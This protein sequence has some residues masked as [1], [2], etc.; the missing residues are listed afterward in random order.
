[1][2]T[3]TFAGVGSAF[4]THHYY[5]SNMIVNINHKHDLLIDCGGD[6]RFSLL[7]I[8]R[9]A[10]DIEA[11]YIS[12]L[13]ADHIGGLEWLGFSTYFN[14]N[15]IRPRLYIVETLIHDLWKS[16]EAGMV[17]VGGDKLTLES[18]FDVHPLKEGESFDYCGVKITP[19]RTNHVENMLS[20]GLFLEGDKKLLITTDTQFDVSL[21]D[22][23][24]KADIILQDCETSPTPSGVHAHYGDLRELD[25]S[26]KN[27]MWLYHY[28]PEPKQNPKEDGFQGFALPGDNIHF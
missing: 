9:T 28:Q 10:K 15:C 11:V 5:Q 3:L 16:L 21:F 17:D 18:Y 26:V 2:N 23:Y 22:F 25:L 13:H 12:H 8:G 27:K 7:E 6:A 20:Y 1:M 24:R 19:F 14:P 4:T